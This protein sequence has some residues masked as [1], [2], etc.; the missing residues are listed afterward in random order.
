MPRAEHRL[1]PRRALLGIVRCWRVA[2]RMARLMI[3]LPDYAH[4]LAHMRRQHPER[5]P[6]DREAFFRERMDAR[7]ARGR[8]RCC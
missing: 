7:Y 8:S 2:A 3:G 4:Y 6:L 5:T 1:R